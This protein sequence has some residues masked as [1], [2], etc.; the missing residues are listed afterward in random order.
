MSNIIFNNQEKIVQ[1]V[2]QFYAKTE[3][4][5]V[6]DEVSQKQK[7]NISRYNIKEYTEINVN[8]QITQLLILT[9]LNSNVEILLL[10]EFN[11]EHVI[12]LKDIS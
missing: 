3:F 11:K 4:Q 6:I 1:L 2:Q 7:I 5:R 8:N 12:I 10:K 9:Y